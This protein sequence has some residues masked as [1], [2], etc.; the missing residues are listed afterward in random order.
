M[1]RYLSA[2]IAAAAALTCGDAMAC[3]SLIATPGATAGGSSMVTYAADSHTLYGALYKQDAA[4]HAPGTMRDVVEWDTG[5]LLG[6]I[7]EV[8]HTYS[9][10][11]NMNEHGLTISEST[12]GGREEL[13]GSGLI[14][15]GS[16]IY[17]TLQRAKNAREAIKVMTD[18]VNTYGY[19]SSG[20]S[21]SIADPDEAWIMELIGKG[22]TDK[23]AVWVARRVPDG[24]ICGHANHSRIHKFPL[25]DKETLYSPDVISFARKQGYFDGKDKD[26]DF[27]RAYA[28]TDIGAVRGCDA[29]VWSFFRRYTSPEEMD[30]YQ[31]WILLAEG[32]PLHRFYGYVSTGIIQTEE[33]AAN[34]YY[35]AL[36]RQP[37][38]GGKR[39][40]DYEWADRNGDG[41]ITKADQFCLGTTVPPFTGGL[42][43]TFRLKNWSLSIY[44]DWAVGHSIFDSSYNRYFFGTFTN[45][46]ALARE[47]LKCWKK[48]GDDTRF[49]K[50]WANDSNWGNDNYNRDR[51][52][53]FT[54]KGDYLCIREITL[55]YSLPK[56][57]FTKVGVKGVTLTVSG[58]NL[59]YFTEVQGISPERGSD[60]TYDADYY[61]YP[62][63]RRLSFG[64]RLIF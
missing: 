58:N 56:K 2:I 55:Q 24:Y 37:K 8:A 41:Q 26:F 28:V 64:V 9:T 1:H 57:L 20:E 45:N 60:T 3:T 6:Q 12:W 13:A 38:V 17:I 19:A 34:A 25:K 59:H 40:G 10:I 50:F 39:V 31:P 5:K 62:P 23:G 63:I 4:D 11:G 32:E 16:L 53:N 14:D 61:N 42:N 7:P 47:V 48:P 35:D 51:N 27:S 15:Y 33:Q 22:K 46:Y 18:L 21:F 54:Y 30:V 43:N 52:N 36:A 44:L 29:R 49:A